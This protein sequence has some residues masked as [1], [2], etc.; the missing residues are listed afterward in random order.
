M[1][2]NNNNC[3]ELLPVE[4]WEHILLTCDLMTLVNV[5]AT[6]WVFRNMINHNMLREHTDE[7]VTAYKIAFV[8]KKKNKY[9]GKMINKILKN[10]VRIK[11]IPCAIHKDDLLEYKTNMLKLERRQSCVLGL[12]TERLCYL[13]LIR[14]FMEFKNVKHKTKMLCLYA[15]KCNWHNLD[16]IDAKN[17]TDEIVLAAVWRDY[18]ALNYIKDQS[19]YYSLCLKLVQTDPYMLQYSPFKKKLHFFMKV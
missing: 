4:V 7:I 16:Y 18:N 3:V 13:A 15:I 6:C 17:Q 9:W 10:H 14:G 1:N 11:D 12:Q 5:S 2:Q 19:R 8:N